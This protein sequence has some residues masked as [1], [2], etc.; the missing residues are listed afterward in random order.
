[1]SDGTTT[2]E[3]TGTEMTEIEQQEQ[4]SAASSEESE[5]ESRERK[6]GSDKARDANFGGN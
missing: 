6:V 2:G 4:E 3:D 5:L 1:M